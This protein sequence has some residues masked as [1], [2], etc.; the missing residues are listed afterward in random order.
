[1]SDLASRS[2]LMA[3]LTEKATGL[4]LRVSGEGEDGLRGEREAIK[5]KW[6]LGGRKVVYTMSCRLSEAERVV[7]FRE[8]VSER[9]WGLPP[10]TL[11][12][13]TQRISG[14]SRSGTRQETAVGGGGALDHAEVRDGL[15]AV[16]A[17]AGWQLRLEGG[18]LP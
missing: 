14:W 5:A 13:E 4:G 7:H 17:A 11:T 10:P 18:R 2:E 1:M 16:T 12:V 15:A 3:A 8:A 6:W 9:A